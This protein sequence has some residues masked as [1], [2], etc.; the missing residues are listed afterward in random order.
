MKK[1]YIAGKVSGEPLAEC[2]MKF[3]MAQKKL[4]QSGFTAVNPLEV[5]G[6][7]KTDWLP[8]MKLCIKALM[9]C[10]GILLLPDYLD[11]RGATIERNLAKEL[12][13]PVSYRIEEFTKL[14]NN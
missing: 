8:A 1:I 4:E 2:T 9:D 10:D 5:V 11:S 6:N 12:N 7:W 14:W 13:I 3:G